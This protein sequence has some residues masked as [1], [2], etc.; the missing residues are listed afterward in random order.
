MVPLDNPVEE[1]AGLIDRLLALDVALPHVGERR[2]FVSV[3]GDEELFRIEAVHFDE[4]VVVGD[5]SVD[6]DEN[7]VVIF[8][9]LGALRE[10]LRVL[11]GERMELED[12]AEN[13]VVGLVRLIDVDPEEGVAGEELLHV[14]RLKWHLF[15][16]TVVNDGA[17]V[18]R[19][20]SAVRRRV[21]RRA[22]LDGSARRGSCII[23]SCSPSA[24]A[25]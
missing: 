10:L 3:D 6:H 25:A 18:R 16:A 1:F 5:G 13:R 21:L 7:E 14:L 11:D 4:A 23:G 9:E 22:P 20:A 19:R 17:G 15:A 2:G 24:G 8:V 12:V